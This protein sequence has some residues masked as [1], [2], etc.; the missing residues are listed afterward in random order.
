MVKRTKEHFT[1]P[2]QKAIEDKMK[3]DVFIS[4]VSSLARNCGTKAEPPIAELK[5]YRSASGVERAK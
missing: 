5:K 3:I 4:F 1:F 2:M